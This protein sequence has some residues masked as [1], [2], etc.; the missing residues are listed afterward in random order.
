MPSDE[1]ERRLRAALADAVADVEP[2][3]PGAVALRR[4][5]GR[6]R[7]GRR[8][9]RVLLP[10]LAAAAVLAAAGITVAVNQTGSRPG[11]TVPTVPA[12]TNRPSPVPSVTTTQPRPSPDESPSQLGLLPLCTPGQ[13][14]LSYH[15]GNVS[16]GADSGL[17]E[18]VDTGASSCRLSGAITVEP[19]DAGGNAIATVPG[20]SNTVTADIPALSGNGTAP[21]TGGEPKPG[22]RWAE[23]VLAGQEAHGTGPNGTCPA[24]DEVTPAAWRLRGAVIGTVRNV[25]PATDSLVPDGLRACE[26]GNG[27]D[28]EKVLLVYP[29]PTHPL[30]TDHGAGTLSA[31][32]QGDLHA[33]YVGGGDGGQNH[34]GQIVVWNTGSRRCALDGPVGFAG[35]YADGT[36]D[37]AVQLTGPQNVSTTLPPQTPPYRNGGSARDGYLIAAI[38][39]PMTGSSGARCDMSDP[40][41]APARFVLI[42]GSIS[43]SVPNN[44]PDAVQNQVLRGCG[45]RILLAGFS[46]PRG[47]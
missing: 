17:I 47:G 35:Y 18:I 2:P 45:G 32:R 11:P 6:P 33:R 15:A 26:R 34:I 22:M 44:D 41:T 9:R 8:L 21:P 42:I 38:A 40:K 30:P 19:L 16:G 5:A 27:L 29:P 23:L 4:A 39:G 37:P 13:L 43:L 36:R 1:L 28:L 7:S 24:A 10:G 3:G 46:A 14:G 31:C 12:G 25:D 20:W